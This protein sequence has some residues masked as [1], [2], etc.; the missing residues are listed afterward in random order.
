[1][2]TILV[3]KYLKALSK[4]GWR[5]LN[6]VAFIRLNLFVKIDLQKWLD[7]PFFPG[8]TIQETID[9]IRMSQAELACRM[10][11]SKEK[12]NDLIKGREPLSRNT[13]LLLERVLGIPVSFWINRENAYREELMRIEQEEFLEACVD[14]VKQFLLLQLK[15]IGFLP[16]TRKYSEFT[17][18]L[19]RFFGVASPKQ[20]EKTYLKNRLE[21]SFLGYL[22][23]ILIHHMSFLH[24]YVSASLKPLALCCQIMMQ[25]LL[26]Q[27]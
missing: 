15:K 12:L 17:D 8:D 13:A 19:L 16:D 4:Y 14:W 1:L 18:A 7:K 2:I 3:L 5:L 26:Q 25:R 24:G 11:R 23:L 27:C 9:E 22:W 10:G 21:T 6:L 20:W